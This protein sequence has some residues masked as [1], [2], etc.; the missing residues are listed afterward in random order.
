MI[1]QGDALTVLASLPAKS[2]QCVVTSPPYWQLRS[3]GEDAA[4]IGAELTPGEYVANLVAVGAQLHRVLASD[5]TFWLNLGDSYAASGKGGGGSL[6]NRASWS[7]IIG[8][9]GFRSPPPGYK[10]KDITLAPF[11]VAEAL[12]AA[13]WYLRSV[14]VWAKGQPSE[15]PRL[16]RPSTS[17]EYLFLLAKQEVYRAS[18]PGAAWWG[19]TVWTIR[20]DMSSAHSATMPEELV[21]RC[22]L[23]GSRPGDVV[24][25]PFA[26]SGTTLAVAKR[27]GREWLGIELNPDY[28]A[29]AEKRIRHVTH[30]P[31]LFGLAAS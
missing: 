21:R 15:P 14:I 22:L 17:H 30:E 27:L 28:I 23:V 19:S 1:V 5:G 13:G 4:E 16:D 10:M 7:G 9:N 25:D 26:G 18:N 12:R 2:V 3:Y 6:R 29:L 20:P 8:R 11:K 31:N 24:L